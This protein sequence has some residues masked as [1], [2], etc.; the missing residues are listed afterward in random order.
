MI[1]RVKRLVLCVK[2]INCDTFRQA[3]GAFTRDSQVKCILRISFVNKNYL[4]SNSIYKFSLT[5]I[6]VIWVCINSTDFCRVKYIHVE[7]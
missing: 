6:D 5:N 3:N 4:Y 2:W 7:S 1:L